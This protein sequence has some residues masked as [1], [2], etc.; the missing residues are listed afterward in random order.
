[1]PFIGPLVSVLLCLPPPPNQPN[2]NDYGYYGDF[3]GGE[4]I[5]L[6]S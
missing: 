1:M 2:S 4:K 6:L 3:K 5:S